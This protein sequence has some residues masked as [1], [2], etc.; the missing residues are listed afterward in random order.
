M[1]SGGKGFP[2]RPTLVTGV[3]GMIL[4]RGSL[5]AAAAGVVE[6]DYGDD[7]EVKSG[8]AR[9]RCPLNQVC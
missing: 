7:G 5:A 4:V 1:P 6:P 8:Q 3:I 9:T 2:L